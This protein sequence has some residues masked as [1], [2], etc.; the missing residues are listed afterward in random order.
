MPKS[1]LQDEMVREANLILESIDWLENQIDKKLLLFDKAVTN[2]NFKLLKTLE[3]DIE[4]LVAKLHREEENMEGYMIK[5]RKLVHD[6]KKKML[7]DSRQK[8]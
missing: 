2:S 5:Y 4:N 7:Y 3:S 8:K 1:D 6:E